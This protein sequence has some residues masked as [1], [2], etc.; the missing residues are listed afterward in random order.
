M[1]IFKLLPESIRGHYPS[2]FTVESQYKALFV[3]TSYGII[4]N[5]GSSHE[6]IEAGQNNTNTFALSHSPL[7]KAHTNSP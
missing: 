2:I 6:T 3:D 5:K 4:F 7:I 1:S